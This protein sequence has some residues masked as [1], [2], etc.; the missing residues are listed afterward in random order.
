[1]KLAV[2]IQSAS[3]G[4]VEVGLMFRFNNKVAPKITLLQIEVGV[5]VGEDGMNVIVLC[6]ECTFATIGA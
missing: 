2:N 5:S 6:M 1:M 3:F 4:I